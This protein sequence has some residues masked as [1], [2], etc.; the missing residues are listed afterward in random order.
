LFAFLAILITFL[1]LFGLSA[2]MTSLKT[3]EF[4]IRKVHGASKRNLIVHISREYF[5]LI[6]VAVLIA[7][8]ILILGIKY[9]LNSFPERM[10]LSFGIIFFPILI[11]VVTTGLSVVSQM[12]KVSLLNPV[13]T[14]KHN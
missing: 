1:G 4:S 8:P 2:F 10:Q 3:R 13:N 14:L 6:V 5:Y 11:I 9:W 7:A 12:V